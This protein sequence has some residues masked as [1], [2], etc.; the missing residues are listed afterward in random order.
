MF[1]LKQIEY[2]K[3]YKNL[4]KKRVFI[5]IIPSALIIEVQFKCRFYK[6]YIRNDNTLLILLRWWNSLRTDNYSHWAPETITFT[7]IRSPTAPNITRD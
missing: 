4:K 2:K 3:N 6:D 1:V 5:F 7:F